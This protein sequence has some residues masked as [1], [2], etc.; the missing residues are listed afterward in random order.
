MINRLF[1]I[2]TGLA[3]EHV[4]TGLMYFRGVCRRHGLFV[5]DGVLLER[6]LFS[7][8]DAGTSSETGSMRIPR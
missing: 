2:F 8:G 3:E 7:L 6:K 1:G 5:F 4:K